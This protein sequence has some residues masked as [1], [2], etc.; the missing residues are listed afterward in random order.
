MKAFIWERYGPPETLR[1]AEVETPVPDADEVLVKVLATSVNAADW[2]S[3]RGKPLFSRATLGI[4]RPKHRILGGDVAGTVEAVGSGVTQFR[5][6][7]EVYANLLD[8][9]YGG[10]AEY[11]SVPVGVMSSKPAN[12]SFEEAAAVPMAAVTAL[13]GL[14]HHGEIRPEQKVLINGASGGVGTFAV[15]IAKSYGPELTAVT[16]TPNVDLARSLGADHVIDYTTT[17]FV[18]SGQHFDLIL[19]TVGNR[20]VPDLRRG[21][22]DRGKAAVTGFTGIAKLIGVSLRGGSD[23]AMVSAHVTTKDLA[24]VSELI[25]SGKVRPEID[26]RYPFAEIPA[27]IAYLEG[28][29]ARG[30]VVASVV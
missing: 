13:Q 16:S 11:V 6:G 27:A 10:F 5:P 2:H 9:G 18:L 21:L 12:L 29:H 30:K 8:H 15:Q 14:R 19:D 24:I 4:L 3:L 7:D 22:A 28:G 1:M 17:D 20:S 25:E 23:I 26:R